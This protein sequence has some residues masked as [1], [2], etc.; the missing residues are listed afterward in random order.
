M[1]EVFLHKYLGVMDFSQEFINLKT[2]LKDYISTRLS[3]IKLTAVRKI[4]VTFADLMSG[5]LMLLFVFFFLLFGSIAAAEYLKAITGSPAL[6]YAS[7]SGGYLLL[8]LIYM[9]IL[10]PV[11]KRVIADKMVDKM[12]NIDEEEH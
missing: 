6:A 8:G 5:S 2:Q 7:V 11:V 9:W 10:R 1:N 12:L 4:A 3:I